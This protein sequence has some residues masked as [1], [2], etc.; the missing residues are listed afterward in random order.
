MCRDVDQLVRVE[1]QQEHRPEQ[2]A[3]P[4]Q[5]RGGGLEQGIG[6]EGVVGIRFGLLELCERSDRTPRDRDFS[7]SPP[8]ARESAGSV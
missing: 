4:A 6:F 5:R 2:L 1:Q 7:S 8:P 3:D